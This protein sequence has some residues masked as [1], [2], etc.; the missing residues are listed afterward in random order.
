VSLPP[1]WLPT[2]ERLPLADFRKP[3]SRTRLIE[4]H[5]GD[6]LRR[7]TTFT[8]YVD[9]D[10]VDGDPCVSLP[11][12]GVIRADELQQPHRQHHPRI[13]VGGGVWGRHHD[14]VI[15]LAYGDD[16]VDLF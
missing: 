6:L 3:I 15:L 8:R 16:L 14:F 5:G 13:S 1:S 4:S 7:A 9:D 12:G 11:T 2:R 10:D